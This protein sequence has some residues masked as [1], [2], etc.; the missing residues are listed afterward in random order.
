M[1]KNNTFEVVPMA[2]RSWGYEIR[3]TFTNRIVEYG[4]FTKQEAYAYIYRY[5]GEMN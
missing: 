5:Y 3:N 1:I 2:Q 4:F